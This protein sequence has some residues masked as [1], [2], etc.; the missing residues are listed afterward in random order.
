[1]R[2]VLGVSVL[3]ALLCAC[4]GSGAPETPRPST[5]PPG[6]PV[7]GPA[8]K[9]IDPALRLEVERSPADPAARRSLAIAL[10]D[11]RRHQESIPHFEKLVE[12]SPILRHLLDLAL[13]YKSVSRVPEAVATYERILA[14][15][16]ENPIALHNLGNISLQRGDSEAAIVYYRRATE[17]KPDY[18]L[19][20]YHMG[21][22]LARLE[23]FEE[24]YRTYEKVLQLEPQNP[25]ELLAADDAL[26]RLAS[27]DLTMGAYERAA[28]FL[29]QV[30]AADPAHLKAHHAY[31][32]A[33]MQL[34]RRE[35]A[36]RQ[37]DEHM[38][39]LAEQEPSGP[40]ASGE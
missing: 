40:V 19:A 4:G 12:L 26:Y 36:L 15:E 27:I 1:M 21:E 10:H 39:L 34:G 5:E 30:L 35:E 9:E 24:A 13:A 18:L 3:S 8:A 38:R 17:A 37:F 32:Q 20:H 23:R 16:P 29:E 2:A 28:V 11:A 31:G 7:V 22:A 6:E 33:L 14:L 25:Q